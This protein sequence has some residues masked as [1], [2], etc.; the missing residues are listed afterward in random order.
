MGIPHEHTQFGT[1]TFEPV[2]GVEAYGTFGGVTVDAY[3]L[4]LQSLYEDGY[5]Y[6]AGN[7]YAAGVG[8]ASDLGRRAGGS[9]RRW[10]AARR[11]PRAGAAS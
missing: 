10:S 4:T 1:G 11:A 6:K 8:A 9:G 2:A 5:G 3:F 7:R